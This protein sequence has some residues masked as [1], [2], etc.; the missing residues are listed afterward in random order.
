MK[1]GVGSS[2][3]T[4]LPKLV[5]LGTVQTIALFGELISGSK[6]KDQVQKGSFHSVASQNLTKGFFCDFERA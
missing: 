3:H 6:A 2:K 1:L 4:V 5:H